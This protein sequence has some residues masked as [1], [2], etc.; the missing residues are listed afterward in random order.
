MNDDTPRPLPPGIVPPPLLPD[1]DLTVLQDRLVFAQSRRGWRFGSDA[2][3]LAAHV[4]E[5]PRGDLL[6]VGTGCGVVCIL[7][8]AGGW[9]GRLVALEVQPDLADRARRN[10]AANGLSGRVEVVEG[11]VRAHRDLLPPGPFARIVAN[12]PFWRLGSGRTNPHPERAAARHEVLLDVPTLLDVVRERLAPGGLA[13][14]LY[15]PER[16]AEV[17]GAVPRASLSLVQVTAWTPDPGRAPEVLA[18]DLA[19]GVGLPRRPPRTRA[20]PRPGAP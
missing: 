14:L 1:E 8:A 19:P 10:A 17:E 9:E 18:L 12:P 16:L 20:I 4:Q 15:P 6:E 3:L 13:T 2:V 11:D 5:G 7:L